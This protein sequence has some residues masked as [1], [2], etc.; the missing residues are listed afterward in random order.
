MLDRHW[1]RIVNIASV[2]GLGGA[3][4]IS[5]YSAA[6]HAVIGFTRSVAAETAGTGVTANAVCPGYVDTEMTQKS[7]ERIVKQTGRSREDALK[8][9]LETCGQ[10]ALISPQQVADVVRA[11]CEES[12]SA[13]TG[14][15]IVIDGGRPRKDFE[16]INPEELGQPRGWTNGILAP[17]GARVLFVAGQTGSGKNL[18]EQWESA[19]SKVIAV[20]RAAGGKAEQI[21]RMTIYVTDRAAY[22]ANLTALG[23]VHRRFM[24]RYYPA[25]ALVEVRGLVDPQALVEIEATAVLS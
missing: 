4:Y 24:G 18:V 16:L 10:P 5:A 22:Q 15:A 3:K 20:V 25:M 21:G 12:G 7:I 19:L 23:E 6:K 11:L 8:A 2:A 9:I 13:T 17:S 1:G 14:E